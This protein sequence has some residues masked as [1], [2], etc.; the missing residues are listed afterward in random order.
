MSRCPAST[1]A[2]GALLESLGQVAPLA[3]EAAAWNHQWPW[4]FAPPKG[5]ASLLRS[6]TACFQGF[7][8]VEWIR[9]WFLKCPSG[10]IPKREQ[11]LPRRKTL[12]ICPLIAWLFL[13]R[14]ASKIEIRCFQ[15]SRNTYLRGIVPSSNG[16][17]YAHTRSLSE[18]VHST[19]VFRKIRVCIVWGHPPVWDKDHIYAHLQH[20]IAIPCSTH[21]EKK[22]VVIL[23][24]HSWHTN[25]NTSVIPIDFGGDNTI[26]TPI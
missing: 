1:I 18:V 4:H 9:S 24:T 10:S 3:A 20:T 19:S 13:Q 7:A 2:S 11:D 8:W 5:C 16:W 14:K 12:L 23:Y 25:T 21:L 26:V 6:D 15:G 22:I 17:F